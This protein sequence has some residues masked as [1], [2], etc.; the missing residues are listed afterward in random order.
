MLLGT[1]GRVGVSA[2][3]L[4]QSYVGA[5][6]GDDPLPVTSRLRGHGL[7]KFVLGEVV[8]AEPVGPHVSRAI[9][10]G[11]PGWGYLLAG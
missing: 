7:F 9:A 6:K 3:L 5:F 11:A 2:G 10:A 1:L 8:Q 4:G